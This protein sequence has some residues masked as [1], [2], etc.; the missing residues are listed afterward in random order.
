MD[1]TGKECL[2]ATE[3]QGGKAIRVNPVRV[4]SNYN[5]V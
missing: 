5:R 2:V 4:F 1:G 3:M